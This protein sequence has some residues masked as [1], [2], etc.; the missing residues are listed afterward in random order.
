MPGGSYRTAAAQPRNKTRALRL[1]STAD[2]KSGTRKARVT[3]NRRKCY[4]WAPAFDFADFAARSAFRTC[5]RN[6]SSSRYAVSS[7]LPASDSMFV[8]T[9]RRL[10]EH[11]ITNDGPSAL[12]GEPAH[13]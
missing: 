10:K 2:V 13:T 12:L 7:L 11:L 8:I 9:E 5:S 3:S 4:G 1:M 6:S